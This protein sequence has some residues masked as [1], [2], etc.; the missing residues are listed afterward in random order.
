MRLAPELKSKIDALWDKF[1]SGGLSNPLSSIEQMSYLIFMKRLEDMDVAE[2]KKALAQKQTYNSVFEGNDDCKWS[3]WKH[4]PA[5]KML[6]HVRD[7]VFP[8]IKDIHDGEKT[9]FAEHMKDAVFIIPKP[10][11]LQEAVSII[12]DL[13]ITAQNKD[14]QGDIYEYLLNE[15]KTAGKN[16]QFR[17]PRHII[18]MI[19]ELVDPDIGDRVCDPAC[20]TAGFLI[21]A[22]EYILRKHTSPDM[23]QQDGEGKFY[24]LYGDRIT[25]KR[26]WKLVWS[27]FYGFDFDSTMVRISLMNM[28][29][30]G[31]TTPNITLIDT[32]SRHYTE[33]DKYTVVLANP[34]FKGSIDKSD[35]NDRL[36]VKTTKT[37]LLFVERMMNMLQMGG[38][39]GVIVPD[40][41]LFGSSNAHKKLRTLLLEKCQLEAIVSMPSGV[42]KP[43][44]GVSTA[45]LVFVKGDKT[46][47]VWFYD[48]EAD[49]YSLDDKRNFIDGKGD[50]PDIIERF[51]KR[52]EENP[53]DRKGKCFFVPFDEI[54]E[55][56]YDLSISRYKEIEYEEIDYD[57]PEV[58]IEKIGSVEDQIKANIG[59]LKEMLERA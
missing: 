13:N 32:L 41:V 19:V 9:L 37:E 59:E 53:G 26:D 57:P 23:I 54:K 34:P 27:S 4:Y 30:H 58:I 11:L 15:L 28:V 1:W 21:N 22:Y 56:G 7:V 20:G 43:Y 48:M 40:G 49:G 52:I 12:D 24:G 6:T 38:K 18:Q 51:R 55:K 14:T 45:V 29:L 5:E 16:G 31:I 3:N 8:F 42:F 44:A 35:I 25:D 10:S 47:K 50:I 46:D 17:T 33:E 36:T 39:C 2:Q